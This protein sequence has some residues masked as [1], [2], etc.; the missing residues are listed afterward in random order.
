MSIKVDSQVN[1][2]RRRSGKLT[3]STNHA[4]PDG[5]VSRLNSAV[6]VFHGRSGS[7]HGVA[8]TQ[9]TARSFSS[10]TTTRCDVGFVEDDFQASDCGM[11]C[12]FCCFRLCSFWHLTLGFDNANHV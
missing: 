7:T 5:Q 2:S 9:H 3:K 11:T 6:A 4:A 10:P 8:V 1:P 12:H